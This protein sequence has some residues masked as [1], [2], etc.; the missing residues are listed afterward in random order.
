[1][2]GQRR[3]HRRGRRRLQPGTVDAARH[4]RD[5]ARIDAEAR[6]QFVHGKVRQRDHV[7][8]LLRRLALQPVFQ[9]AQARVAPFRMRERQ[10][11]V[12]AGDHRTIHAHHA[13][14][15]HV[16]YV[17][18]HVHA[19][20]LGHQQVG[21]RSALEGPGQRLPGAEGRAPARTRPG[22]RQHVATG[23]R[24]VA[25]QRARI[26]ADAVHVAAVK[27]R[28]DHGGA[29]ADAGQHS[30]LPYIQR[31]V[32]ASGIGASAPMVA[33]SLVLSPASVSTSLA[34]TKAGFTRTSMR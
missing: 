5:A 33:A 11:I 6:D 32:S 23:A 8:G 15:G 10:R 28:L 22:K 17:G 12:Q 31:S 14:V 9:A 34:R 27:R 3:R 26:D 19:V 25:Q 29:E 21:Q 16:E 1:V 13:V 20:V 30:Q 2:G 24:Q 4:H 18:R 7:V